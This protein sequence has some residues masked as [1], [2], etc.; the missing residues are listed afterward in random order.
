ME[1]NR[2][3]EATNLP[4]DTPPESTESSAAT[5]S[6]EPE[7]ASTAGV[8]PPEPAPAP[9]APP[10]PVLAAES[11]AAGKPDVGKRIIAYLIDAVIAA[12]V[13]FIPFIGW[14]IAG[15]YMAVRDG[16]D[17]DFMKQRS[18]GKQLMKLDVVRLDGKPMDIGT[19]FQRNWMWIIGYL[20][21]IP[22]IG[23]LASPIILLAAL[24][25]GV[26][27]VYK[28]FSDEEGRRWGDSMA[29]TKVIEAA[30]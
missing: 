17:I 16:L 28:V 22:I 11:N 2:E 24:I 8:A 14:L 18:L 30:P 26:Y 6:P 23:W 20:A 5:S 25:I 3:E 29:G 15:A 10:A 12:A 7:A 19:S 4:P 21:A 13:S 27:E 1:P 9:E